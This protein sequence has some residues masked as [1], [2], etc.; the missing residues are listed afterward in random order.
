MPDTV[1]GGDEGVI[2]PVRFSRLVLGFIILGAVLRLVALSAELPD[3]VRRDDAGSEPAGS[4]LDRW[5]NPWRTVRCAR[6]D[7]WPWNGLL[8]SS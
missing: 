4:S 5:H 3:V 8:Y 7:F 1:N 6:S 2:S